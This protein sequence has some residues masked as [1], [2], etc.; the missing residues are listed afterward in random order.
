MCHGFYQIFFG[1]KKNKRLDFT[2]SVVKSETSCKSRKISLTEIIMNSLKRIW[3]HFMFALRLAGNG[4]TVKFLLLVTHINTH[5]IILSFGV[6][7]LYFPAFLLEREDILRQNGRDFGWDF[8][9]GV[10]DDDCDIKIK[11]NSILS[12]A[13]QTFFSTPHCQN[14]N[15]RSRFLENS[16]LLR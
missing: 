7:K 13:K 2:A 8:L 4:K 14:L 5:I 3:K 10:H 15:A 9:E 11:I 12:E 6:Y 1:P 16:L